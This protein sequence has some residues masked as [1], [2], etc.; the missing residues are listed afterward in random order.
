MTV[1]EPHRIDIVAEDPGG[2]IVLAMCEPRQWGSSHRMEDE[3]K[4]KIHN[5]ISFMRSDA[6]KK[7][8]GD[9]DASIM[10]MASYEPPEE[11]KELF[12]RIS[13]SEGIEIKLKIMPVRNIF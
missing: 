10:L 7:D 1:S 11:I 5:Y 4:A 13:Y 9:A 3:L 6:Y 8:Y 12:E 2:K